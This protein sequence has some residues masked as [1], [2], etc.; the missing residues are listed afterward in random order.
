M[1]LFKVNIIHKI[2]DATR[3]ITNVPA[4]TPPKYG[5]SEGVNLISIN[6]LVDIKKPWKR[7]VVIG[8]GKTGIDAILYLLD[9]KVDSQRIV[10]IV[11]NDCWYLGRDGFEDVKGLSEQFF[12][13]FNNI[14]TAED[15]NDVY[16]KGEAAGQFLRLDKNIWPTKMRAATMS[17][18]E[19]EKLQRIGN[20]VRLG[21]IDRIETDSIIFKVGESIPTDFESLHIDC[22]TSGSD[23][24]PVKEKIFDGNLINL[25]MVQIP[26]SATSAAMIA[27]LEIR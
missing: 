9:N 2:V 12:C 15:I 21:R 19:L 10:W 13:I 23:F 17:S 7:Y 16:K 5:V 25:Q 24:P 4:T 27:A 18:Q 6:G 3:M 22:S 20:I 26:P 11:S 1:T 14:L 8:A